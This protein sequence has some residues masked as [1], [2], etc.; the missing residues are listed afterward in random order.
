MIP[1]KKTQTKSS[2]AK[3]SASGTARSRA[4]KADGAELAL[5]REEA[6]LRKIWT[7]SDALRGLKQVVSV[8][9]EAARQEICGEV[10]EVSEVRFNPSASN[11]ATK[12]IEA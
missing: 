12:A 11:A 5:E 6:E 1:T 8:Y 9:I 10:G 3:S 4:K 7:R 2:A